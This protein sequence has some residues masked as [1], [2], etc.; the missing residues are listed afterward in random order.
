[1]LT[2]K[3]DDGPSTTHWTF[4]IVVFANT[5]ATQC[6][7]SVQPPWGITYTH[8][9]NGVADSVYTSHQT[10]ASCVIDVTSNAAAAGQHETG[11]FSGLIDQSA[12]AGG[13]SLNVTSGSFD[14]MM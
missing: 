4:Q 14:I 8:Y 1:V 7:P 12:D 3:A 5:G 11:T 13:G 10:G 6:A 9:T 2:L